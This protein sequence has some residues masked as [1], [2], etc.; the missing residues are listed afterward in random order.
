MNSASLEKLRL[1]LGADEA[2][3]D[4]TVAEDEQRRD[5]HDVVAAGDARVVV[6][7]ELGDL[8]R[9]A[10]RTEISSRTGA[11]ILHGPHHSAQKS[12]RSGVSALPTDSSKVASDSVM[13]PLLTVVPFSGH[14]ALA[15]ERFQIPLRAECG[16]TSG[17]GGG[18]RLAVDVVLDVAR[19]EDARP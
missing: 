4:L 10:V 17:P 15:G 14:R 13:I 9:G 3:L 16:R 12:T 7:V 5:A 19:G 6:D 2:L 11:I 18:D 8:Q 1:A